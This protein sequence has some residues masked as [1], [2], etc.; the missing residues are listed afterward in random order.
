MNTKLS[1]DGGSMLKNKIYKKG[2][3]VPII[4]NRYYN[5]STTHE[6]QQRN[7][8]TSSYSYTLVYRGAQLQSSQ[9][10]LNT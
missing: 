9:L 2:D 3:I 10:P 7:A 6:V 8:L 1:D 5:S 4:L